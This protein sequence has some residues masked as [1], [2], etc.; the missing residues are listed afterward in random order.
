M[1]FRKRS[2]IATISIAAILSLGYLGLAVQKQ[3]S[4]LA[5]G[6]ENKPKTPWDIFFEEMKSLLD[7]EDLAV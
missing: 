5:G 2:I 7:N 4:V 3:L 1:P 6:V